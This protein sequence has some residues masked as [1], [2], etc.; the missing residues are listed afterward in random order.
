M[1]SHEKLNAFNR[2]SLGSSRAFWFQRRP[3]GRC[4]IPF[5]NFDGKISWRSNSIPIF[6]IIPS[7]EEKAM[8]IPITY[9]SLFLWSGCSDYGDSP[10]CIYN[11]EHNHTQKDW[12][13][14]SDAYLLPESPKS[15]DHWSEMPKSSFPVTKLR[16]FCYS[17]KNLGKRNNLH[18]MPCVNLYARI[19]WHCHF[20][21]NLMFQLKS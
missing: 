13:G 14:S 16:R 6:V 11:I 17:S 12:N 1:Y 19:A 2:L 20:R 9:L 21:W 7:K 15:F 10:P 5:T 4:S 3:R 8:K 18:C